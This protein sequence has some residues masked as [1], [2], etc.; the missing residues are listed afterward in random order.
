[1]RRNMEL[2]VTHTKKMRWGGGGLPIPVNTIISSPKEEGGV[3]SGIDRHPD[4]TE[5]DFRLQ[6][7]AR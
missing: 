2:L 3:A 6:I 1:M 7:L 4:R 5:I